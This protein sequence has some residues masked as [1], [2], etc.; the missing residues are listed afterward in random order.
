MGFPIFFQPAKFI[1][2]EGE[3]CSDAAVCQRGPP[4]TLSDEVKSVAYSFE[5]VCN[6]HKYLTTCFEA[7]LY[8]GFIGSLY[9]GEVI[10]RRGRKY[11]VIESLLMM[12]GGLT[13]S[14][15]SGSAWL[16]SL[17][18]FFFNAGFRGFYNASFLSIAEVT[19]KVMR[20]ST[21]M[22]CSIGWALG[23]IIIGLLSLILINWRFIFLLTLIPLAALLY[24]VYYHIE[25]SPRF[26]VTKHKFK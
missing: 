16:F 1:C 3:D 22:I 2:K 14:F 21:P 13:L 9:Y 5:L 6:R 19:N 11:A 12:I 23:Q 7:F 25:D 20:A 26:L 18:V 10:E 8:G 24:Y 17:G 15:L 4:Y